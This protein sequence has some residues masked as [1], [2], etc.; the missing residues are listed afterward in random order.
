MRQTKM[1]NGKVERN[2]YLIDAKDL[3]LGRMSTEVAKLLT[4][5]NKPSY[6]PH[7]DN[8]DF[9]VIINAEKVILTGNKMKNKMYYNHSGYPGGLRVRNAATMM[10]RYPEELVYHS[11]WG[12]LPHNRLGRQQIKKL[13]IY[14]GENHQQQAQN[15]KLI[16]ISKLGA[17][18]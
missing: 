4:G 6:T 15:P 2:W 17:K 13:Y 12:M 5:K 9:V 8:G 7:E 11:I 3:V 16:T 10:E 14:K 1:A 18:V